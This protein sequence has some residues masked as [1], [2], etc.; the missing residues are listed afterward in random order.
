MNKQTR[1]GD[2]QWERANNR[3]RAR[4]GRKSAI[5]QKTAAHSLSFPAYVV[6][7]AYSILSIALFCFCLLPSFAF[8]IDGKRFVEWNGEVI[9]I[10]AGVNKAVQV[11]FPLPVQEVIK[12]TEGI[13]VQIREKTIF[14]KTLSADLTDTQ[15]FVSAQGVTYPILV[16]ISPENNDFVVDIRDMR[17]VIAQQVKEEQR[18]TKDIDPVTLA[19]AMARD[20][21][22][23][24]FSITQKDQLLQRFN[25]NGMLEARVKRVYQS[26]FFTGFIVELKNKSILPLVISEQDFVGPNVAAVALE[27]ESG[28]MAPTPQDAETA[29]TGQHKMLVYLVVVPGGQ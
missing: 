17:Q 28:Y 19:V 4:R 21:P 18:L 29:V 25:K 1:M 6:P 16:K 27:R 2:R 8:A 22:L 9:L 23:A 15:I 13:D 10:N 7:I 14:V 26:P 24:G 11:N 12:A 20:E 5:G 3:G